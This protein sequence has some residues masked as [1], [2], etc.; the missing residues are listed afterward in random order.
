M[1][2]KFVV[3]KRPIGKFRFSLRAGNGEII[4]TSEA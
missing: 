2:A 3:K 1:A 4:A